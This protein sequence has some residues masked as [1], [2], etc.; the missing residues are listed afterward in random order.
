MEGSSPP[1]GC[2]VAR[3]PQARVTYP[4]LLGDCAMWRWLELWLES[5]DAGAA[6]LEGGLRG[7]LWRATW[8]WWW[9]LPLAMW[10]ARG[11]RWGTLVL[12]AFRLRQP[13]IV[14]RR[15]TLE[16]MGVGGARGVA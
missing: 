9:F 5:T 7:R 3:C 10:M 6:A 1:L 11:G 2:C 15:P 16:T 13:R 12:A 14:C 4:V 8:Q